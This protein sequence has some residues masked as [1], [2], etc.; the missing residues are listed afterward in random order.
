M[1]DICR[2]VG[3]RWSFSVFFLVIFMY[4]TF[5]LSLCA[6]LYFM[7]FRVE[8]LMLT[9]STRTS[10]FHDFTYIFKRCFIFL[11][12]LH[13]IFVRFAVFYCAALCV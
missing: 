4:I 13:F 9:I 2:K 3:Q 10:W 5:S 8:F 7:F 1:G 12:C 11:W 6:V